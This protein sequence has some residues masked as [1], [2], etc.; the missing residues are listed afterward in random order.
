M[1]TKVTHISV[2]GVLKIEGDI[3]L[4][5]L[6]VGGTVTVK[7]SLKGKRVE[8]GGV[9]KTDGNALIEDILKVGGATKV[10]GE[11]KSGKVIVGGSL[12][13]DACFAE[14]VKVGGK[15]ETQKGV[16]A[17]VF[18]IGRR[19]KVLGPIIAEQVKI[20]AEA[21]AEDIYAIRLKLEEN[22]STR[23]VYAK[24]AYLNSGCT[25]TGEL[26]YTDRL[27]MGHDVEIRTE[28]KKVEKLPEPPT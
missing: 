24:E 28:P 20:G 27:E 4:D 18:E 17:K 25:V 22:S 16:R 13:A 23:N 11:L 10:G 5:E 12:E 7:G 19:G 8:V 21:K 3:E 2:G 26:L 1:E 15:V 6:E 9:L 14:E